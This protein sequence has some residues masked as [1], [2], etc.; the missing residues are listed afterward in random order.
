MIILS[1]LSFL[2]KCCGYLLFFFALVLLAVYF[3]QNKMLYVP[4][5][6]N[7]AFKYPENNPPSYRNPAERSMLYDDVSI[8]TSDG[9]VL[10]G[11]F[12]K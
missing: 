4:D 11:W 9:L 7:A 10:R 3:M 1:L 6:P 8:T 2:L 5:A 12:M